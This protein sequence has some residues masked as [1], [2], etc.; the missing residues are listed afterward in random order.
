[1]IQIKIGCCGFPVNKKTYIDSFSVVELQQTFYEPPEP[2]IALRWRQEV[3]DNFEFTLKAWQLI[4]HTPNSPTYKKLRHP[5]PEDRQDSYGNF[6]PT[7]EV[8]AAWRKTKE[9]AEILKARMIIFSIA[10][11]LF[12]PTT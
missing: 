11:P 5:I 1:M 6:K 3:P 8:M 9:I 4:T 2:R 10:Q 12:K 7:P